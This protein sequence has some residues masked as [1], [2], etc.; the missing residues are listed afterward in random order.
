MAL[1]YYWHRGS[2]YKHYVIVLNRPKFP[3]ITHND[4]QFTAKE[5]RRESLPSATG[6][7]FAFLGL[8]PSGTLLLNL[9][10]LPPFWWVWHIK[11][12]VFKL[13]LC[14]GLAP[15][16]LPCHSVIYKLCKS[17]KFY[18]H[19]IKVYFYSAKRHEATSRIFQFIYIVSISKIFQ[20]PQAQVYCWYVAYKNISIYLKYMYIHISMYRLYIS[21]P[22]FW[23]LKYF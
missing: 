12:W 5:S 7:L 1:L 19:P 3:V 10:F 23:H 6:W 20:C 21:Y 18:H 15:D 4:F 14:L 13:P 22:K 8:T 11:V 2:I 17:G 16:S 9:G